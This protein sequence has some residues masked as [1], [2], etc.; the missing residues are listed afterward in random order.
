MPDRN[1][2]NSFEI[3]ILESTPESQDGTAFR[4]LEN[5]GDGLA[6]HFETG[7]LRFRKVF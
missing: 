7:V 1:N 3:F 4:L 5:F 6:F 2:P